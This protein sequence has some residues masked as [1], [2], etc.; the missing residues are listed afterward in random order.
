MARTPRPAKCELCG[1]DFL[2]EKPT[3]RFCSRSCA[4]MVTMRKRRPSA[5]EYE[6]RFWCLVMSSSR[7]CWEWTGK[8]DRD[9]YGCFSAYILGRRCNKAHRFSYQLHDGEIPTGLC[10]CHRCDNPKCVRHDHLFLGTHSE[11]RYDCVRKGRSRGNPNG[12][13]PRPGM[14]NAKCKLNDEIVLDIREKHAAGTL[15]QSALA[16]QLGVDPSTI[17]HIVRRKIWRHLP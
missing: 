4:A 15:R 10:V 11:N 12:A 6:V 14:Q 13:P 7:G 5:D 8:L 16:R 2:A 1:N 9:G 3:N 17:S